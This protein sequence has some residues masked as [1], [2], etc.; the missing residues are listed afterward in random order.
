MLPHEENRGNS[1]LKWNG[2]GCGDAAPPSA[3]TNGRE[4]QRKANHQVKE[5][6]A[7]RAWS[8]HS[9]GVAR[10]FC[11]TVF[12]LKKQHVS[13]NTRK[14][15]LVGFSLSGQWT[16]ITF[17]RFS[18]GWSINVGNADSLWI[19]NW[20]MELMTFLPTLEREPWVQRYHTEV[21]PLKLLSAS[22][23]F[24]L[25]TFLVKA[26]L[27]CLRDWD[28]TAHG[29]MS[30]T[31]T[32]GRTLPPACPVGSMT[33]PAEDRQGWRSLGGTHQLC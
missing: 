18:S 6:K 29:S 23:F 15:H 27:C 10:W 14:K 7:V 20:E 31:D 5:T 3:W 11:S 19:M 22:F 8:S 4:G 16:S 17:A 28:V 32:A 13:A 26:Y 2:Q 1:C 9:V 25:S 12:P 24:L 21:H 33:C 30:L